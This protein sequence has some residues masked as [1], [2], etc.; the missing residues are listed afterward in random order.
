MGNLTR[1]QNNHLFSARKYGTVCPYCRTG[2]VTLEKEEIQD[3]TG[4]DNSITPLDMTEKVCGW[5]VCIEGASSGASYIVKSGRNTVGRGGGMDIRILGDDGIDLTCHAE[6]AYDRKKKEFIL[7]PGRSSGI[8]YH[9]NEA[10]YVPTPL[11][12]YD[13]IVM[14]S[15]AFLLVEFAGKR[16]SWEEG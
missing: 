9:E 13:R 8:V 15:S 16:F 12:S 3:K 5:L 14:G 2:T 11:A 10:V 1:C 7:L 6:I 4:E